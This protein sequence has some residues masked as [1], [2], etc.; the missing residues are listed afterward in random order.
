LDVSNQ[1]QLLSAINGALPGDNIIVAPGSYT[2]GITISKSGTADNWITI[3]GSDLNNKPKITPNIIVTGSYVRFA[4]FEI[5]G[6]N[7][8]ALNADDPAHDVI[9]ENN[10]IHNIT[11]SFGTE[12]EVMNIGHCFEQCQSN[13]SNITIQDNDIHV[14]GPGEEGD[15]MILFKAAKGGHVIRRNK[16]VFDI[17]AKL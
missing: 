4:G 11:Q 17:L 9:F 2:G 8:P 1:S 10:Y 13:V 5:A 14:S 3:R 16:L 12:Q 15:G 7:A 6:G